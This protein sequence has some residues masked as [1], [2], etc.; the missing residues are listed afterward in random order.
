MLKEHVELITP[1]DPDELA[2]MQRVFDHVCNVRQI[3]K[4]GHEATTLA[5]SIVNM[6]QHGIRDERQLTLMM[7]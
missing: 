3:Q 5:A 6:Y 7:L 2:M 4:R 1:I